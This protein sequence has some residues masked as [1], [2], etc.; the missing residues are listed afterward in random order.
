[1]ELRIE[2]ALFL[3]EKTDLAKSLYNEEF[4]LKLVYLSNIFSKLNELNSYLQGTERADIFTVHDKVRG[5]MK[6]LSLWQKNI[7]KRNYD[8]FE[9]FQIFI[10]ENNSKVSDDIISQITLHLISLKDNFEF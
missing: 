1:M 6:K 2:V 10:A 7:E 5:F 8:C 9:T 4:I 3:N